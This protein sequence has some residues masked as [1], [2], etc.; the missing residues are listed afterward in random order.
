MR[1]EPTP[2]QQ[3]GH[4]PQAVQLNEAIFS[5]QYAVRI[6]YSGRYWDSLELTLKEGEIVTK[7]L[8]VHVL[9]PESDNPLLMSHAQ[10]LGI[11]AQN[12]AFAP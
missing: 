1:S 9:K 12:L 11:Y 2:Q 6:K 10:N 5:T 3:R 7:T 8:N 4:G